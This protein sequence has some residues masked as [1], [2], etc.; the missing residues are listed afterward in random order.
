MWKE[1]LSFSRA[2]RRGIVVLF[3][4]VC[5]VALYPYIYK[6]LI[7]SP[8]SFANPKTYA[9]IDS[10]FLSL[11]Y[12]PP[13]YIA[14]FSMADEEMPITQAPKLFTFDPNSVT[15]SQLVHLGF[16]VR[17]AAVIENFRARGGVFRSP[18]DFA[19]MYVV[20]SLTFARLKPY[21]SIEPLPEKQAIVDNASKSPAREREFVYLELNSAD[22]LELVK[23]RGIG[24]GYARRIVAYRQLLGGYHNVNQLLEVY[25][26]PESLL[27]SINPHL[28]VDTISVKKISIN[29][30]D[31]HELRKHPY[32]NDY[33]ARAIIYYRETKGNITNL[34]DLL[35]NKLVDERTYNR[36]KH[37]LT[38]H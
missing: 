34:S 27:E 20:D 33:Q 6:I 17:Q 36:I 29:L 19:K 4:L 24:R 13:G 18:E 14:P 21:I 3:T 23:I 8:A 25:G 1:W 2:E 28:W 26:F 12:N 22:T 10:F 32:L 5:F 9:Q 35:D 38:L 7:Y 31:Y 37:Y 30:I 11:R 15:S 16:S